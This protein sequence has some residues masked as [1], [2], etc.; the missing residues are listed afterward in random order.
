V[1]SKHVRTK[2][3]GDSGLPPRRPGNAF[4]LAQ[5]GAHAA[6]RFAER[7]KPLDLTPAQAGLLRLIAWQPG[8]SQQEIART[9]GTPPSRLVLLID[10]L[11]ERGLIERRRNPGDRRHHALHLTDG[12]TGFMRQLATA[13]AAHEDDICA[14]LDADERAQLAELLERIAARQGLTTG[15]HPGYRQPGASKPGDGHPAPA[16][17]NEVP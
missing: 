13:G 14:G 17:D 4:L 3:A 10:S 8:R 6:A 2:S 5:L 15:V 11:E 12:G 7:I 16:T 1:Y 9:L